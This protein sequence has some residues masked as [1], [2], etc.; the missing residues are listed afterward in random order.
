MISLTKVSSRGDNVER[1]STVSQE[2][3]EK[4]EAIL[5]NS[6]NEIAN[7]ANQ[8][9]GYNYVSGG[10][11]PNT[12]FDCSGFTKYV[13]SN[14]GIT[15]DST[16]A[17]QANNSG[18]AVSREDLQPGD[19]ILFQDDAKTKI[20]HCGIYIGDNTFIHA[21]NPNRGVVTDK[22]EGNSYYSPRYVSAYRF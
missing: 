22:L 12:G 3:N 8:Y 17:S 14:F 11:T 20:G 19:L 16:A 15:L 2:E 7:F 6:G 5:N 13:Y 4:L 18:T 1:E 9:L 10:K 21:A